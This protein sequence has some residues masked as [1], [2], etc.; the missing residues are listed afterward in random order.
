MGVKNVVCVCVCVRPLVKFPQTIFQTDMHADINRQQ[1][2]LRPNEVNK[3]NSNSYDSLSLLLGLLGPILTRVKPYFAFLKSL[4][5]CTLKGLF[6]G[7]KVKYPSFEPSG[8]QLEVVG[9]GSNK[10]TSKWLFRH[11]L[12]QHSTIKDVHLYGAEVQHSVQSM[13]WL[14]RSQRLGRRTRKRTQRRAA[15]HHPARRLPPVLLPPHKP[16]FS[17]VKARRQQLQG[18]AQI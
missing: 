15:Y 6:G 2:L 1:N 4:K 13:C 3:E 11:G 9:G 17:L 14:V 12:E 10:Q 5:T 18:A 16:T 7:K 8:H